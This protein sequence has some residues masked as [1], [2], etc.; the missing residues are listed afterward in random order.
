MCIIPAPKKI[1][2]IGKYTLSVCLKREIER[3]S[4]EIKFIMEIIRI[5]QNEMREYGNELVPAPKPKTATM[6]NK[7]KKRL[8]S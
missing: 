5:L 1:A 6:W 8:Q 2:K 3:L 7:A 4:N